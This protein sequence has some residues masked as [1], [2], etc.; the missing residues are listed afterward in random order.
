MKI[1]NV[2]EKNIKKFNEMVMREGQKTIVKFYASWCGHCK[3]LNRKWPLIVKD[4][5]KT[6]GNGILASI[7]EHMIQKL[8]CSNIIEGYPT[9]RYLVGG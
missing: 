2:N 7:P 1:I 4:V 9:I 3:E 8:E 6:K 5:K